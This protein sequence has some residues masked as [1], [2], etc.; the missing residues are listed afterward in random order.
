[1]VISRADRI[2]V[3]LTVRVTM[4]VLMIDMVGIFGVA[5]LVVRVLVAVAVISSSLWVN[6]RYIK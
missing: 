4:R 3:T 5:V 2:M 1:M 6:S